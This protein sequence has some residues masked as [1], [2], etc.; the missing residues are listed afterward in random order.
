MPTTTSYDPLRDW[1][2]PAAACASEIRDGPKQ[3][4]GCGGRTPLEARSLLVPALRPQGREPGAPAE[5]GGRLEG[6]VAAT[7][8]QVWSALTCR[9]PWPP[10]RARKEGFL[11]WGWFPST[12]NAFQSG[13]APPGP[14]TAAVGEGRGAWKAALPHSR[15][16]LHLC[17]RGPAG[18]AGAWAGAAAR[19]PTTCS[20]PPSP[21]PAA[22]AGTCMRSGGSSATSCHRLRIQI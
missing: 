8:G 7:P 13:L 15:G 14:E 19:T 16:L 18:C 9:S 21:A 1:G 12:H 4:R 22:C 20:W 10:P 11:V 3:P 6:P 17:R 2:G 5:T